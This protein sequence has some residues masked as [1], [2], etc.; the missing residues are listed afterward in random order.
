MWMTESIG[1]GIIA[2]IWVSQLMNMFLKR[3]VG[4]RCNWAQSCAINSFVYTI[5]V[6]MMGTSS[7][8]FNPVISWA[9]ACLG[10]IQWDTFIIVIAAQLFGA[11]LGTLCSWSQ[12][13]T[14]LH[15]VPLPRKDAN[16][17][18]IYV[19]V[20][21]WKWRYMFTFKPPAT[22]D[23]WITEERPKFKSE[24]IPWYAGGAVWDTAMY[25]ST[26][27]AAEGSFAGGAV[28]AHRVSQSNGSSDGGK[29]VDP[30]DVVVSSL[31]ETTLEEMRRVANTQEYQMELL[32]DQKN[33]LMCFAETPVFYSPLWSNCWWPHFMAGTTLVHWCS[34]MTGNATQLT[35]T[36]MYLVQPI[37]ADGQNYSFLNAV[38]LAWLF[39]LAYFLLSA[40]A[41]T[42][43]TLQLNPAQDLAGRLMHW[44]LPIPNKGHSGWSYAWVPLLIPF[45]AS[46][47]GCCIMYMSMW[48]KLYFPYRP[49]GD[50]RSWF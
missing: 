15:R 48:S 21:G 3:T 46:T 34:F 10:R 36:N 17:D 38:L 47:V 33:K 31:D 32:R 2:S 29:N 24:P 20:D 22:P 28:R 4:T 8:M 37:Q 18:W 43:C 19:H 7:A 12:N 30:I 11:I 16:G 6:V 27:E 44:V 26:D 14:F 50:M 35:N 1:S 25:N 42:N 41:G 45:M 49:Y 13:L 9:W 23:A 5:T 39:G 40:S